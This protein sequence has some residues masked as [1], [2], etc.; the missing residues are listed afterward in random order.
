M[1]LVENERFVAP[2]YVDEGMIVIAPFVHKG[3]PTGLRCEVVC[4]AGR[5]ARVANPLYKFERWFEIG[6]LRVECNSE[7]PVRS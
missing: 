6:D 2:A 4:A 3:K 1:G 7:A 5:H